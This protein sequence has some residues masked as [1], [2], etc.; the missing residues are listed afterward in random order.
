MYSHGPPHMAEQKQ[1]DQLEPTYSSYV[2]IQDV[3][4]K[5]W[6][7]RWTIG[8]SG[9]RGS[10]ISV[11]ALRHEDDDNDDHCEFF[12]SSFGHDLSLES[13]RQVSSD[14][15]ESSQYSGQPHQC[16][17]LNGLDLLWFL[18]LPVFFLILWGPFQV[19]QQQLASPSFICSTA[20]FVLWEVPRIYLS[21]L[22][23][24]CFSLYGP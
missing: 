18:N 23:F 14:L 2:R 22:L 20:F 6:Q 16:C 10:G 8:R 1:D 3:A 4:L 11:L 13:K 15:P 21:F 9:E 5:T 7:R 24:F 12:T 19:H 17:S